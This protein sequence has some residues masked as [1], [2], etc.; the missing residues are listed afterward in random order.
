MVK[1]C[2]PVKALIAGAV[3]CVL[4]ASIA[5][6]G[7]AFDY[8]VT[9]EPSIATFDTASGAGEFID[10]TG[11]AKITVRLDPGCRSHIFYRDV[12]LVLFGSRDDV[13]ISTMEAFTESKA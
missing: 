3:A 9:Y 11:S 7:D 12:E 1:V 13:S 5:T 6:A 10:V 8:I 4:A 2:V